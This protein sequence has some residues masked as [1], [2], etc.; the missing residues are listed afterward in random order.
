MPPDKARSRPAGAASQ[1]SSVV[2]GGHFDGTRLPTV[3]AVT[4]C[5]PATCGID[6]AVPCIVD[7]CGA[8]LQHNGG[9]CH[10]P[11]DDD[12]LELLD[13][14]SEAVWA[15]Y[16]TWVDIK[17]AVYRQRAEDLRTRFE[18]FLSAGLPS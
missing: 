8:T 17:R 4:G 15:E 12:C 14:A 2:G 18:R 6:K 1:S 3:D 11:D 5:A 7:G 13:G 16:R 10:S 9:G